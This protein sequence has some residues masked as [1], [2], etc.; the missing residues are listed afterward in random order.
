[1]TKFIIEVVHKSK[2]SVCIMINGK[3]ESALRN[4]KESHKYFSMCWLVDFLKAVDKKEAIC[5]K[6]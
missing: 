6:R 2:N 3:V 1:M 5:L 4:P